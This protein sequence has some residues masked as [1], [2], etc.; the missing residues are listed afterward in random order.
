MTNETKAPT[1]EEREELLFQRDQL[2]LTIDRFVAEEK[3]TGARLRQIRAQEAKELAAAHQRIDALE[4]R[5]E[6]A[7]VALEFSNEQRLSALAEFQAGMK[8]K[9]EA[10]DQMWKQIATLT[11][12]KE[13]AEQD[14]A[15]LRSVLEEVREKA[16]DWHSSVEWEGQEYTGAVISVIDAARKDSA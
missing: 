4:K 12:A 9:D 14:T 5:L 7:E 10:T 2:Q 8:A 16:E 11:Q 13:A 3:A 1:R 15:R 6:A